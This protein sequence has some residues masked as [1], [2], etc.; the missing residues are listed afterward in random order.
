MSLS[1]A[2]AA[3]LDTWM[4]VIAGEARG[5]PIADSSGNW[6]F[7]SAR[8]ALCVY[9]NG[10]YHDFSGGAREHGFNALQLIQHLYPDADAV[11]WARDWLAQ[12]PG[13]GPFT[14]QSESEP[15][16]DFAEMEAIAFVNSLYNG[17]A[18]IDDT[19]GYTYITRTRGLPLRPEDMAQLR[20]IADDRGDEGALLTP[21]TDDEGKLV[22]LLVT[23]VTPDGPKSPYG[24]GRSTIRGA[25]RSGL[26]RLGS[27]GP[28]VVETEGLE[29][30]LAAR[31]AGAEHVVITGGISN[32]GKVPL[33][34]VAQSVVIA[35][36][37]DPAGSPADQALWRGVVRRAAQDIS[38][39][40]TSRPND[41]APKDAPPLKDLDDVYRYDP[42]YVGVLLQGA[43][44][45]HGR[46]GEAVDNAIYEEASRLLPGE[47]SHA[48][49]ALTAMLRISKGALDAELARRIKKRK[50]ADPDEDS[51]AFVLHPWKDPVTDIGAVLDTNVAVLKKVLAAPATHLDAHVLWALASHLLQRRELGIRHTARL[52][53]QSEFD[54]SGKTTAMEALLYTAARAK[55]TSS[56]SGA[57][58]Y[59]ETD[60]HHYTILWDEADNAFHKNTAPELLGVF[61]SGWSRKFS[62]V[63]RQTPLP[64]GGFE[65]Q[66]F[67]TFTG[68]ALTAIHVFPQKSMQ[69]RCIVL[70]MKR[71][72]K[73]EAARLVDFDEG[74]ED[75]L[76]ECG[77]KYVRWAADLDAL[78]AVDKKSFGLI[79]RIW[80]NWRVLLQI[81]ELAGGT[82]PARALAA[83]RADMARVKGEKDDSPE[84]A[85]LA[86]IWRVLAADN[87]NPRRML[88][89][90]LL[91]KLHEEDD[92]R[93]VTAGQGGKP[94]DSYYLR[95]KL[96]KLLPTEGAYSKPS[97][98]SW[99]PEDNPNGS[100]LKGYHELH[101]A[102]SFDR[103]LGKDLPSSKL[104]TSVPVD[105]DL[106]IEA[107][108]STP[109]GYV[110]QD[111]VHPPLLSA[112]PLQSADSAIVSNTYSVADSKTHPLHVADDPLQPATPPPLVADNPLHVADEEG[113]SATEKHQRYQIIKANVADRADKSTGEGGGKKGIKER[114]VPFPQT[115]TGRKRREEP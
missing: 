107:P 23:Y 63:D 2:E 25:K 66:T 96:K 14:A 67:D 88:T 52:A 30:G 95:S 70:V 59:R 80:L 37:A 83:A 112:H 87:S 33:P 74:H 9:A 100:P 76:T 54:D 36:D 108:P 69:G 77:Q 8:S 56:L 51:K 111:G 98:R 10:Q 48:K 24:S 27:P 103:Y 68:I 42:V 93:W 115:P 50:E 84:Y 55:A 44:L 20:W 45:E 26:C 38:T 3:R 89:A 47:L 18:P 15:A 61:N 58:M 114:V 65:N 64:K 75:A 49:N 46:L 19:P 91:T 53:F 79:N 11:G 40:V 113:E 22:K 34:P 99:R 71:A 104:K 86:A 106:D 90:D 92:G 102:E 29:K 7:G 13:D 12:H 35:R 101:F 97:S 78:P 5:T 17:A 109:T 105:E 43:N 21:V 6:R 32:L 81:A 110:P 94:I 60:A 85:L 62:L 31:A 72:T 57:S 41:V 1:A 82:W 73:T 39:A 16:D 28:N 4:V